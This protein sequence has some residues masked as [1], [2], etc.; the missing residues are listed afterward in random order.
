MKTEPYNIVLIGMSGSGKS[1]YGKKLADRLDLSFVDTDVLMEEHCARTVDEIIKYDGE[2]KFRNLEEEIFERSLFLPSIV[3]S[4]GGGIV[5]REKNRNLLLNQ[6]KVV[7]LKSS[8]SSIAHRLMS[9]RVIRPLLDYSQLEES[10]TQLLYRREK[11]YLECSD[12]VVTVDSMSDQE[13]LLKILS[14]QV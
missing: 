5:E 10:V 2:E 14:F 8:A 4:T 11:W 1:F 9:D 12:M 13:V 6:Q 7:Y 3:L